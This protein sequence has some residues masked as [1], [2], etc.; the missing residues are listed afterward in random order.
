MKIT[1]TYRQQVDTVKKIFPHLRLKTTGEYIKLFSN[2]TEQNRLVR[3][4]LKGL[5]YN[6][7]VITPKNERPIKVVIKGYPKSADPNDIKS[8]KEG[9][10]PERVT[11]LIGRRSKQKLPVFQVTLP[12]SMENLKI[13]DLKTLAHL[14]IT[15]DGYNS[16][17]ITQCFS[18]NNFHHNAEN[19]FLKPR[20]LK[21]GEEHLTKDCPIK[22]RLETKFCINCQVYGHMANWYGCPCFPKTPKGATKI[23]RNSYTSLYNSFVRPNF[24]YAHVTK[25]SNNTRTNF[26]SQIKQQMAPRRP[27]TSSQTEAVNNVPP[28]QNQVQNITPTINSNPTPNLSLNNNQNGNNSDIKALL[29][30]T[31]QCLIQLL[32]AMNTAPSLTN[33]FDQVNSAQADANQINDR[34]SSTENDRAFGGTLILVKCAINHYSLPTSPLQ[35]I[36]ATVVILTPLDHDPISKISIYIPPKSDEYTFT[37]DIENL[38]QTSSNCVLFCDFNA[39]HTAW[40]CKNNSSRGVRLLDF[41]NLTNLHIAYPDSPTRFGINTSNILDIAIIRNFYY[42]YTINSL[43]DLSSDH[44]PVLLNFTLKLNKDITNPRAV[45]TNWPLF[46]KKL[47]ANLSLLNYHPNTIKTNSDIDKKITEFIDTVGAAHNHASRPIETPHKSYTPPHIHKLIKQKNQYRNLYHRTLDPHYKTLYNKAQK[48]VKKQLKNYSNENWTARLQGLNTQDN[49]PWAVQKFLKNKRSDI[50]PLNCSTGTVVTDN[51]KANI[52]T[53]S[54]LD[55]FTENIRNTNDFDDDDELINNTV[56]SFL[57]I[58]PLTTTE[59]A[60]PSEIISYIKKSNSKKAPGKDGISNRMTKNFTLKAI[61]ILTVLINKSL[62]LN[63][64]PKS[65]KEAIIFPILKPGK[66]K[67]LPTSYRPISLLPKLSKITE[68]IILTRLKIFIYT[69][70]LL[71]PNQ[72]GFTNKLST[73][74]PLL[75]LTEAITEGFQNK[76]STGAVFLD[77]QKA[78]DRVWLTGLTYKL[79]NYNLPP[80]LVFLLH[81]YNTNRSYQVRVKDTLSNTKNIS[82][83]VA[84]GSL[85]GPLLF[86]LYIN[87]IPDYTLTKLNMFADDTAIRT[88]YKRITSVTYALNKHLK[89]LEN[90]YNKWKISINLEKSAAVLF[91]KK[92]KIP[93]PPTIYNT[94]I[95]WSQSTKYLGITF[96]KNLTWKTHI[97]HTR[98]KFR[99]IMFKLFPLIGRNSELSRDNKVLLYTA[100]MRPILAYGCPVW[101]YAAKTNINILDTLQNS[102]IRMIVKATRYM[103]ND[104]IR[105]AIKIK[106]FKSYIQKIAKNFFNSLQFTNNIH[107]MNLPHYNPH[108]TTKRPRRILL[109]SYNPP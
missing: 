27:E 50:S 32:N 100:V 53:D 9:F 37:I 106:S 43:Y 78:F 12:R 52:L 57:S 76:K 96:D 33:S 3:Q 93:P 109:D 31:V 29:S 60:Y 41:T 105:N 38:I 55:N 54:I 66:N 61:L 7:Y 72:Y 63:Y 14:N 13:F 73:L 46:S 30:T 92:R 74:H 102:T 59:T 49:S 99:K 21:C 83:G 87:D 71:N 10:L 107:M 104:D 77:I 62:T 88:T 48:N 68:S 39:P 22:Q 8:E 16:K 79:I 36:E 28:I 69:N 65:W 45:P 91:T 42:P 89:L 95:P 34:P 64:F 23:I 5:G 26:N 80:P 103:R 15:V 47:N 84:Q 35:T 86:N 82:Y 24:S 56:N 25:N 108:V 18:C 70:N 67:I 4:T 90:Y 6:F 94:T 98:Q 20:C 58:P 51:Q 40:N 19:C 1:E 97:Q 11:Q 75:N 2:T 81:S 85:L 17:G 101:G 44:N